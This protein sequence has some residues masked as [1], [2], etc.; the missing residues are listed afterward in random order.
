MILDEDPPEWSWDSVLAMPDAEVVPWFDATGAP[1]GMLTAH[2][3]ASTAL[4]NERTVTVYTP[5]GY[6]AAGPPYPLVVALDGECWPPF[7]LPRA[8]D[9][10]IAA[11]RIV[12]PVVAFVHNATSPSSYAARMVDMACNPAL[13]RMLVG[14]LLPMLHAAYHVTA[15]PGAT[16]LAGASFTGLA[17]AHAAL[18]HSDAFG[19]VLSSSGS[20]WWGVT[21]DGEPEWLT[22]QYAAVVRK[23][24]RFWVDVG[25]LELDQG[26]PL[27]AGIDPNRHF[28]TVLRAKGYDVTYHE[29][30]GGHEY[31]TFRRSLVKGLQALLPPP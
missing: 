31:A 30:P 12:A 4:G 18:E 19:N 29:A 28:R 20:F 26:H 8:L 5:P 23:P 24:I 2:R 15:D 16:V 7:G 17:A 11:G 14:E 21:A 27:A 6:D 1:G 22:R 9:N 10:L 13:G 25:L 3:L